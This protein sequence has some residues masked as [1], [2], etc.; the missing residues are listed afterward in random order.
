V[1][2]A[3]HDVSELEVHDLYP[4]LDEWKRTVP[5]QAGYFELI[6]EPMQAVAVMRA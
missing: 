5:V 4:G 2:D 3:W 6:L 1:P